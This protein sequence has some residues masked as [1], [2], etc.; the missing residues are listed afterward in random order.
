M[1]KYVNALKHFQENIGK[2]IQFLQF[3]IQQI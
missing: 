1:Q 3:Q 2:K